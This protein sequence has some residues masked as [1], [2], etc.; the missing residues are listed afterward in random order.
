MKHFYILIVSLFVSMAVYAEESDNLGVVDG[1]LDDYK[2]VVI[3]DGAYP[4]ALN[5]KIYDVKGK[6]SNRYLLKEGDIVSYRFAPGANGYNQVTYIQLM[7][8]G[9]SLNI[10][11]GDD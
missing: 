10:R 1:I 2:R 7:P 3:D 11:R 6:S 8:P 5:V 9:T 4:L